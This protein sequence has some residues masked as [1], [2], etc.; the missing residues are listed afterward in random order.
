MGARFSCIRSTQEVKDQSAAD[1][2]TAPSGDAAAEAQSVPEPSTSSPVGSRDAAENL[3]VL[4]DLSLSLPSLGLP[5]IAVNSSGS[6]S[7]SSLFSS[8]ER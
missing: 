7:S 2:E 3:G 8:S 4:Q 1:P 6:S 5:A